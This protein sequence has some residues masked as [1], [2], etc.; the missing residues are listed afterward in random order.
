LMCRADE[1]GDA[2]RY[3]TGLSFPGESKIETMGIVPS[4][5]SSARHLRRLLTSSVGRWPTGLFQYLQNQGLQERVREE[6]RPSCTG[7]YWEL[8]G[9]GAV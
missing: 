2:Y 9:P 7:G 3:T 1:G 6:V 8:G 5:A 4:P